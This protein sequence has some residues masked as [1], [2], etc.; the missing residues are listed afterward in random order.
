MIELHHVT[1]VFGQEATAVRAVNDLSFTCPR[2]GF[3]AIMGPSGSGKSTVLHLIAGLTA[4]TSGSILVEGTDVATMS[5]AAAAA[6]RRRSIGYVMQAASLLPFLTVEQNVSVPLMLAG[7]PARARGERVARAL[8]RANISH[9]S[10]HRPSHLS[11]GEQQRVAIARAIVMEPPIILADEPTGNL[12]QDGGHAV[13]DLI[14]DLNEDL[15]VTVLMVTHDPVFAACAQ[16]VM[17][18][19]DGALEHDHDFARLRSPRDHATRG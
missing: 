17:R 11:G 5:Q 2:G 6:L 16:R 7:V 14:Q 1:K 4:P 10:A 19:V 13:M 8:E 3:W 9:R 15:G 12:D 18:V